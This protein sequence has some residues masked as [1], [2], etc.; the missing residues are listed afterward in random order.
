MDLFVANHFED[1]YRPPIQKQYQ[2]GTHH[3]IMKLDAIIRWTKTKYCPL[4]FN[5]D[6]IRGIKEFSEHTRFD[7]FSDRQKD[8]IDNIYKAYRLKKY[9]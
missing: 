1:E 8:T 7:D 4:S 3:Y 6:V 2:K 9:E 5:D